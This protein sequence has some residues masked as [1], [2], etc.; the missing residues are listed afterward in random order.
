MYGDR[1]IG[2]DC[3]H[4]GG[5]GENDKSQIQPRIEKTRHNLQKATSSYLLS[6]TRLYLTQC[7][8]PLKIVP[9]TEPQT[10]Q[11]NCKGV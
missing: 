4:N 9:P 5:P 2:G 11:T 6:P 7:P 8:K 10:F 3:L 1:G